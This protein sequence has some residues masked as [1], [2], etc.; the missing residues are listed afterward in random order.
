M[1]SINKEPK[2]P[3]HQLSRFLLF[4]LLDFMDP[5]GWIGLVLT[6]LLGVCQDKGCTHLIQ[7]RASPNSFKTLKVTVSPLTLVVPKDSE[8]VSGDNT[9]GVDFLFL[10]LY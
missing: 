9:K 5:H 1:G 8:N 7:L 2:E 3:I 4:H 10:Y 6:S